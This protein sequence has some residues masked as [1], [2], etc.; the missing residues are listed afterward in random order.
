MTAPFKENGNEIQNG[1]QDKLHLTTGSSA[2][3]AFDSEKRQ[4][5]RDRKRE[6]GKYLLFAKE[7]GDHGECGDNE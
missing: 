6:R 7:R 2:C 4:S 5:K 3:G 1:I